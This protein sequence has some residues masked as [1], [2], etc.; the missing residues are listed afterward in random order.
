MTRTQ[1]TW[2]SG[3]NS[4]IVALVYADGAFG[5]HVL[6][7]ATRALR[8]AGHA[9]AGLIQHDE[10]RPGQSRCDMLLENLQT[11][12]RMTISEQRG[13]HARGCQLDPDA[14]LRAMTEVRDGLRPSVEIL[15]LNKFGKTEAEGGGY[16]PLIAE[17]LERGMTLLIGVPV[18]NLEAWRAFVDGTA[19]EVRAETCAGLDDRALLDH[20]ALTR[21]PS[22]RPAYAHAE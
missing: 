18:R 15:V 20:L 12:T 21:A 13:P 8:R 11:G 14:L 7:S 2:D 4:P 10:P 6:Q 22:G 19:H 16:R 9:C 17:A 3:S 1:S 5:G